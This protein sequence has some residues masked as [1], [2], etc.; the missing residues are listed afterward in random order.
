[1]QNVRRLVLDGTILRILRY[2]YF[3]VE[4]YTLLGWFPQEPRSCGS[5]GLGPR[6]GWLQRYFLQIWW[7]LPPPENDQPGSWSTSAFQIQH[8]WS[9]APDLDRQQWVLPAQDLKRWVRVTTFWATDLD[10]VF[11]LYL[12][13]ETHSFRLNAVIFLAYLTLTSMYVNVSRG[14]NLRSILVQNADLDFLVAKASL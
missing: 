3:N 13:H 10:T 12:K 5:N 7:N 9:N 4:L 14:L 1:M 8:Q 6:S 11:C 2:I